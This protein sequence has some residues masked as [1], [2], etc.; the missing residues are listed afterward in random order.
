MYSH[1]WFL[2]VEGRLSRTCGTESIKLFKG[3]STAPTPTSTFSYKFVQLYTD[4]HTYTQIHIHSHTYVHGFMYTLLKYQCI[5]LH[6]YIS[7]AFLAPPPF[8]LHPLRSLMAANSSTSTQ[9][10]QNVNKNIHMYACLQLHLSTYICIYMF[11]YVCTYVYGN[12]RPATTWLKYLRYYLHT[13]IYTCT[14][15]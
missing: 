13:Y 8:V 7:Q 2:P 1:A 4:T 14:Q 5:C 15:M 3:K 11:T 6:S 9:L 12:I 10:L